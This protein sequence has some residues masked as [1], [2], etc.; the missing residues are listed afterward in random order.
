MNDDSKETPP[1]WLDW[2]SS[3]VINSSKVAAVYMRVSTSEQ[4]EEG[5]IENQWIELK[6]RISR[7]RVSLPKENIYEDNG[8]SGTI[9]ERPGLASLRARAAEHKFAVLYIYDRGR[10]SRNHI[11]QELLI[12]ELMKKGVQIVEIKGISGCSSEELMLGSILGM[13]HDYERTKI[14]ER[15]NLGKKRIV[16]EN[17]ELLGYIPCYGYDLHRTD[18]ATKQRASF[19]IN[20]EQAKVVKAIFESYAN[21]K[22]ISQIIDD[23]KQNGIKSPRAKNGL[24]NSG[25]IRHML[26]N[27]TYIGEHYYRKCKAVEVKKRRKIT[28]YSR[29]AKG[30]LEK[31]PKDEWWKVEGI[32]PIIKKALFDKVQLLLKRNARLQPRNTKTHNYLLAGLIKCECGERRTGDPAGV[33]AYYRCKDRENKSERTCFAK[34]INVEVLDNQVWN[35]IRNLLTQPKLIQKFTEHLIINGKTDNTKEL[36]KIRKQIKRLENE[37]DR[38]VDIFG[39]GLIT[40][41]KLKEKSD[42][43]K[44]LKLSLEVK[45]ME[46]KQ[47]NSI[48]VDIKPEKIAKNLSAILVDGLSFD[49][50]QKIIR[51]VIDEVIANSKEATIIGKIPIYD[52]N[53]FLDI[54][55]TNTKNFTLTNIGL[56]NS[57]LY[58]YI[59]IIGLNSYVKYHNIT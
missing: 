5:T 50:K 23:L 35:T 9:L 18:R 46:Y 31:R 47:L 2:D 28:E 7:D 40:E 43:I 36:E 58:I 26:A 1:D 49:K 32:P 55:K 56:K 54:T 13:F 30:S 6:E 52:D 14:T 8:W 51:T 34:G 29:V 22:S 4:E 48:E 19:T 3:M 37:Y 45:E 12:D 27:T 42:Q 11:H 38:Y 17:H 41:D 20:E 59:Y 24:W 21:G 25:T 39:K 57:Y 16:K 15:M 33:N 10:L 44:D 53:C